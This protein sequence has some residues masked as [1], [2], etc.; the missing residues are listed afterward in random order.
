MTKTVLYITF[1]SLLVLGFCF[2]TIKSSYDIV[3]DYLLEKS[4]RI[5]FDLP[6]RK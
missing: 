2:I 6:L 3:R 4:L 1:Y 5:S